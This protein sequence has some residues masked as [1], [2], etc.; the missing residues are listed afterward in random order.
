MN[1]PP[2]T[3]TVAAIFL[4]LAIVNPTLAAHPQDHLTELQTGWRMQSAH[5]VPDA[6]SVISKPS[7]D[8]SSW[9]SISKM[10]ATVLQILEDNGVY[11]NLYYGMNLE[12]EVPHDLWKQA[13][14]YRTNFTVPSGSE[15]YSLIFKGINYRADV[16]VNGREV[17][18]YSQLVGMYSRHELNI[19]PYVSPG[20]QNA[21]A[22]RVIPEQEIPGI[23]G[24]ELADSWLD[25]INWK[26]IGYEGPGDHHGLS[27]VPD[28]NAGIWK[29]VYLSSTGKVAIRHPYVASDL[30]L[31]ALSPA[32]L[33]VYCDLWNASN[34]PVSGTLTG[35]ITRP[36]RPSVYFEKQVTLAPSSAKEISLDSSGYPQLR[37]DHPDL[38]WPYTWGKPNLYRLQLT[39]RAGGQVSDA[40]SIDFGIRKIQQ[41]RDSDNQFPKVGKGGNF[42]LK[43]NGKDFLIRGAVYT[44]DL[45]FKHDINRDRAIMDDVKDLGLNM[46]RWEAKISDD[47]MFDL[48]DRE[49]VP[50]MAGWMCCMQWE[51]WPQWSA[52]DQWVAR[53]SLKT[54]ILDLRSHAAA[55]IWANGSDGLPPNSVLKDYHR[56]ERDLH[57]QNAIVD[58]VSSFKRDSE[59][60]ALWSGIHME[61][62]YCWR[63]PYYW[64]SG[65]F[66]PPRGSCAEQGDNEVVPPFESLK[67]FIPADKL[68]P[69]NDYWYFHAGANSGN[70]TLATIKEVV[71]KRYGPSSSAREFAEK[72]QLAYYEE[73]RAQFEDFAVGPWANHKMTLYWMLNSNWPSFF[74]HLIDD[75]LNP[76]GGYFGAK[77]GLRP[78]SVVYDDYAT[79]DRS[80]A[81][82][83]V[84]NQ[85]LEPRQDLKV[86]VK[87]YNLDGSVKFEREVSGL[88]IAP[89][90]AGRALTFGRVSGL[91]P[92]FFVRCQLRDKADKLLA[93]NVYWQ[94]TTPDDIGNPARETAFRLTEKSWADFRPLN[95][96]PRIK[97]ALSGTESVQG[98]DS[99]VKFTVAN[100]SRNIAFFLR[101]EVTK[102]RDGDEVLPITYE[103]NYITLFPGE[104]KT[105]TA[106][107]AVFSLG[108]QKPFLKIEGYNVNEEIAA[109]SMLP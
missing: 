81:N 99:L 60:N 34:D 18:N 82:I 96:M 29:P 10:P 1:K 45:L 100:H 38:W 31:P 22:V 62:P 108:G 37:I 15:V 69:I 97:V 11:K 32:S 92:V 79:G 61:G 94:S 40:K 67:K 70:N 59:G 63:P 48:A 109:L 88:N 13:W 50:I 71:D 73:A 49:G 53:Q 8:A 89:N 104:S 84:V 27:W 39:F 35:E 41:F 30:P 93:D 46:L 98:P 86:S 65:K 74:G 20:A 19:S 17:A 7:Y 6:G 85:T 21:L 105:L 14:W 55:F 4:L 106:H 47:D 9:Y 77:E 90:T 57:W 102:G 87:F 83:Y 72:A 44:P 66:R 25:W 64:F 101:V 75:Y 78:L 16:W 58:T 54:Q 80:E 3:E 103:G 2:I 51:K 28:R 23:T 33:T 26:Y 95:T 91:S 68:W 36:G 12:T 43:V 56:I 107:F 24:V 76:G 5:R 42:Y 52:E